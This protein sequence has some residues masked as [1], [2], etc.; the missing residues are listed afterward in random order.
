MS[1][2]LKRIELWNIRCHEHFLFEPDEKGITAVSGSNGAGKSTIVDAFAWALY[3]TKTNNIKNKMLIREGIS[4]KE[5]EVKVEVEIKVNKIEYLIKRSIVGEGGGADCNVYGRA[6]DSDESEYNHLAGPAISSAEAFIKQ[7]LKMDEKGFLTAVLIQQKQVD[8]IV[9][10]SPRERGEVIEKLTGIQSIS[11]AITLAREEARTCQK[12]AN[13]ITVQ[14][15]ESLANTIKDSITKGKSLKTKNELDKD[16]LEKLRD[17]VRLKRED[18]TTNEKLNMQTKDLRQKLALDKER[19][20]LKEKESSSLMDVIESYRKEAKTVVVEDVKLIESNLR[21]S[22]KLIAEEESALTS[23]NNNARKLTSNLK[24]IDEKLKNYEVD[25][26]NDIIKDEEN[27]IKS[28]SDLIDTLNNELQNLKGEE[29]QVKKSLATLS[30]DVTECPVCKSHIDNPEDLRAEINLELKQFKNRAKEIKKEVSDLK[31][32]HKD[33][34]AIYNEAVLIA[35]MID[36]KD[37]ILTQLQELKNESNLKKD[38]LKDL[39][40]KSVV[41]DK[42]YKDALQVASRADEVTRAKRRIL[43]LNNELSKMKDLIKKSED[44]LEQLNSLSDRALSGLRNQ[45]DD[46]VRHL[47]KKEIEYNK[48]VAQLNFLR[49]RV[50][51]LKKQYLSAKE[52]NDKYNKL[53]KTMKTANVAGSLMSEFKENR[54][55][56][57]IPALEMYASTILSKFTDGKFIKLELDSKFNTFVTTDA[58]KIR[59]IAQL[60]GGELSAAAIALRIGISMLLNDG[61]N[62]VLILDEILVSMDD[63]RARHIIETITSMTNCQVIFIAHNTDIQNIADKTV[64]V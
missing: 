28:I 16:E 12:A 6:I 44:E 48:D 49:E 23:I 59:P 47:N 26:I 34:Q 8:Q 37:D 64:Q 30:D 39:E 31:N 35:E 21:N 15:T 52:A 11:N 29:K 60:S 7:I 22:N 36:E 9:A 61:E 57:S 55:K 32:E 46:L 4:P 24:R 17:E 1:M 3:G 2:T 25:K 10:A 13:V 50:E 51:D 40:A 19:L 5:N 56:V 62:N 14:D 38:K 33:H 53:T 27:K 43:E 18:Y 58:G 45:L 54:I 41:L 42:Q 20:K 63:V